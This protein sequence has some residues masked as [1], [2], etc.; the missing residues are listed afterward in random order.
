MFF[1][2][3]RVRIEGNENGIAEDIRR[4]GGGPNGQMVAAICNQEIDDDDGEQGSGNV[5]RVCFERDSEE[6]ELVSPCLCRGSQQYIHLHCL[7]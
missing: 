2:T 5:C 7:K 3:S 6:E 1:L 4:E